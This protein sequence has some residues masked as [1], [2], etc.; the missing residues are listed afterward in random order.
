MSSV[1]NYLGGK[2]RIGMKFVIAGRRKGTCMK[3]TVIMAVHYLLL[4]KML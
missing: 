2:K 4:S 1:L 3:Y